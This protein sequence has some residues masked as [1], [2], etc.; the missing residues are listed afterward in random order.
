MSSKRFLM[1]LLKRKPHKL[2]NINNY[3]RLSDVECI[4]EHFGAFCQSVNHATLTIRGKCPSIN[5][6]EFLPRPAFILFIF[7]VGSCVG[8]CCC[9]QEWILCLALEATTKKPRSLPPL[10]TGLLG[11]VLLLAFSAAYFYLLLFF[12]ACCG[13]YC[14]C[15]CC[16]CN[17]CRM[18]DEWDA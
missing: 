6:A 15:G 5:V 9:G 2:H 10:E 18:L 11:E 12:F 14:C 1:S 3:N 4:L 16:R 7:F 13:C 8:F 17:L